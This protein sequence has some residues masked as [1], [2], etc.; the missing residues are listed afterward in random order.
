M[1]ILSNAPGKVFASK[2]TNMYASRKVFASKKEIYI[3]R[4]E[5]TVKVIIMAAP[6]ALGD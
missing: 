3:G 1:T 2:T 4:K 5:R 6:N